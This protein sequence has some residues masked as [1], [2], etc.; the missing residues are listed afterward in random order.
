MKIA[1][2]LTAVALASGSALAAQ[3][4]SSYDN[5]DP[6]TTTHRAPVV[7]KDKAAPAADAQPKEGVVER[8]KSAIRRMGERLGHAT[9][10][11]TRNS[12]RTDQAASDPSRSDTRAMG[13]A[14]SD[15]SARQRRMDDAYKNWR[16]KQ[17]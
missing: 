4:S 15:D 13:A 3:N 10:R 2:L 6:A 11:W 12:K 1:V 8:T 16:N 7:N 17:K 9:D 14:G 5:R